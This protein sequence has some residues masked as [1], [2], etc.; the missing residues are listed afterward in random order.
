V[1]QSQARQRM[2]SISHPVIIDLLNAI[3]IIKTGIAG[4]G[5][6]EA[7]ILPACTFTVD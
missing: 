2:L 3:I 1:F 7:C 5:I 6:T 4:T